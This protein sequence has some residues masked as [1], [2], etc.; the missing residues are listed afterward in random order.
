MYQ[1]VVRDESVVSRPVSIQMLC[2]LPTVSTLTVVCSGGDVSPADVS[3]DLRSA[4]CG[5]WGV[6]PGRC[7]YGTI[8]LAT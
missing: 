4:K 7:L 8:G 6:V 3:L 5:C 1:P 2:M